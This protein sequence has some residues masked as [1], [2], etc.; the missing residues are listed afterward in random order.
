MASLQSSPAWKALEAHHRAVAGVHMRD[1]FAGDGERFSRFS[2]TQGEV[3]LDYAK[4]RVTAE[5]MALLFDLARQADVEG[6]RERMFRG[7]KINTTEGRA[8]LHTALRNRSGPPVFVDGE[9]VTAK[10]DAVLAHMGAFADAVRDGAWT[11]ETGKSVTDVVNIGIGGSDL[12]PAMVVEALTPYHRPGLGVHFV[13]NVDGSHMAG[14][15]KGLDPETTLFLVASKTFTTTETLTNATAARAWLTGALGDGAVARHFAALSA[16][17]DAVAAFGI[18]PANMFEFWDWVG[19]RYSLWSAIGLS[20]AIA[21]G[22]DRFKA[23]LAGA[24]AMDE[25]FLGAALEANMPVILALLGVWNTDFLGAACHAVL[26]YDQYLRRLPAYLQQADM[27]SNG[28]GVTRDGRAVDYATGPVVFGEPGTNGQHAFYQLLHQGTGLVAADFIAAAESPHA[29]GDHHAILL[30]N[31]FAQTEALMKG[32][33]EA[34][35]R[36]EMEAAG[37]GAGDVDRLLP[38]KVFP[39]NRPTNSIL[40]RRF[41]PHTLGMVLA[42]YEHKIFVQGVIWE[43]NSFDQWGVE[44]GKRLADTILGEL[45]DAGPAAGHDSSTNGMINHYKGLKA[46]TP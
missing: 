7:D 11:G 6:W 27:E 23:L 30:A 1:L 13:S 37:M 40:V 42:L 4:N 34:E 8:V 12:G 26:P 28:K 33:T 36:A 46:R 38:H 3:F 15:L 18:D 10:V 9:D 44:L 20:I 35:A 5:T 29:D 25:H 24:R 16:N 39:G 41:D 31:F 21:V 2:L 14:T 22:M 45:K 19:G 32:R 43:I 17:R